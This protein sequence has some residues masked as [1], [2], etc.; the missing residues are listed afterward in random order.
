MSEEQSAGNFGY[1]QSS[2]DQ[3][4]N[5]GNLNNEHER[6]A[7]HNL[8]RKRISSSEVSSGLQKRMNTIMDVGGSE[9]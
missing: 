8:P 5:V 6:A 1:K 9:F 3:D 2:P 7:L 4:H